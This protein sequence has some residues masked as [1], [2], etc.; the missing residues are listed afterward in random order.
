MNDPL[1]GSPLEA[2]DLPEGVVG[3]GA[4]E[5]VYL[6]A[7]HEGAVTDKTC[8]VLLLDPKQTSEG[9]RLAAASTLVA[10]GW[11]EHA[12]DGPGA[13]KS[14]AALLEYALGTAYRWS[15]IGLIDPITKD[16][17]YVVLLEADNVVALLQPRV[18]AS[19]FVRFGGPDTDRVELVAG[20]VKERF[21][22][23]P[24]ARIIFQVQTLT[25]EKTLAVREDPA[26]YEALADVSGPGTGNGGIVEEAALRGLIGDLFPGV[27]VAS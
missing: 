19:W 14:Y 1:K 26:G 3:F 2:L 21:A 18:L 23:R 13:T 6:L 5:L 9:V 11:L 24:G 27:A 15:R 20:I 25:D 7:R 10:R 12:D 4:A 16:V 17:D 22:A 8:Q